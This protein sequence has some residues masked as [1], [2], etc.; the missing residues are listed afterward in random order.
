[1]FAC[2]AQF[3]RA[4]F[5]KPPRGPHS[6]FDRVVSGSSGRLSRPPDVAAGGAGRGG[7]GRTYLVEQL[8]LVH[9]GDRR[10]RRVRVTELDETVRVGRGLK[11]DG[12]PGPSLGPGGHPGRLPGSGVPQTHTNIRTTIPRSPP[13]PPPP[14]TLNHC[15]CTPTLQG[16][17]TRKHR[18]DTTKTSKRSSRFP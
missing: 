8:A 17:P 11:A 6:P 10:Q 12:D 16:Y 5:L 14:P 7:V 13:P 18:E 1:M 4:R 2:A 15:A 9:G 3:P